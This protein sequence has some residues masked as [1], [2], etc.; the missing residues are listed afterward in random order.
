MTDSTA[1]TPA[2]GTPAGAAPSAAG[3][4]RDPI[5]WAVAART[6]AN[7]LYLYMIPLYLLCIS[8]AYV[9]RSATYSLFILP[10]SAP[11]S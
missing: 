10:S 5:D 9:T 4:R 3:P 7:A 8:I 6:A 11:P 2:A 1:G